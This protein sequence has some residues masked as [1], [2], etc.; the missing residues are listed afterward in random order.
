M[1]MVAGWR[2]AGRTPCALLLVLAAACTLTCSATPQTD[3]QAPT[4]D[5]GRYFSNAAA[6]N[7]DMAA[8]TTAVSALMTRRVTGASDLLAVLTEADVLFQ[9]IRRHTE[10]GKAALLR[11]IDDA[12]ARSAR[13]T[14]RRELVRLDN[15][16]TETIEAYGEARFNE[17]VKTLPGLRVFAYAAQQIYK[18]KGHRLPAQLQSMADQLIQPS[19]E[20]YWMLYQHVDAIAPFGTMTT[21]QGQ[22]NVQTDFDDLMRQPDRALRQRA[23]DAYW[24][25]YGKMENVYADILLGAVHLEEQRQR[26][27]GYPDVA[28]AKYEDRGL[29]YAEVQAG[30]EQVRAHA[31]L[32]RRYQAAEARHF[33]RTQGVAVVEAWDIRAGA[34]EPRHW[35]L[36]EGQA[37]GLRAIEGLGADYQARMRA[38]L[39]PANGRTDIAF[40]KGRR[41]SDN[42]SIAAA[43]VPTGLFVE[44]YA[45]APV[46]LETMIHEGGHAIHREYVLQA[47]VPALYASGPSWLGEAIATLNSYLLYDHLADIARS[48]EERMQARE[49]FMRKLNFELFES[50]QEGILEQSI[51]SEAKN[52]KLH[53]ATQLNSLALKVWSEFDIQAQ[54]HPEIGRIWMTKRLY[55]NDPYYLFNYLFSGALASKMFVM[56]KNDPADFQRRFIPLLRSGF[57]A[58]PAELLE[59]FFGKPVSQAE[60]IQDAMR[61]YAEQLERLE[62]DYEDANGLT[63]H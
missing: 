40:V 9:R 58:P 29:T 12:P 28:T 5:L 61:F 30:F 11:D 24:G 62:R 22:K 46:D 38:L 25:A 6:A 3:T 19:L 20:R 55:V 47:G 35:S 52:G 34:S 18:D 16:I 1:S 31:E 39:D 7:E 51:Y 33:A 63:A 26:M 60:L 14:A 54:R 21:P 17:D 4:L 10:Y 44:R 15:W 13:A 53:N 45:G 37:V 43:G 27:A 42:T 36:S 41:G 23:W 2:I 49:T 50:T 8:C 56:V 48:K 59:R 57:S 32:S